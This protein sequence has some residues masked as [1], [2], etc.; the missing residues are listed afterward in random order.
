MSWGD[1]PA[2]VA[3]DE[4][5]PTIPGVGQDADESELD[6]RQVTDAYGVALAVLL[7]SVLGL[8]AA[9]GLVGNV[10]VYA[11]VVLQMVALAVTLRVSG[12][13]RA[14]LLAG[15]P[16]L[17]AV[18]FGAI[19]GVAMWGQTGDI[20]A[21]VAWLLLVLSTVVS[22]AKRLSGYRRINMRLILGL[23]CIYLLTG[24][25]FGLAYGIIAT[26]NP[27]AFSAP[28]DGLSGALYLSFVTLTTVG[29]GDVVAVSPVARAFVVAQAILGQLYL[30]SV[31]SLAVGRLGASRAQ[32][33]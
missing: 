31:V 27:A 3:T 25:S 17:L 12:V 4:T 22:I 1:S 5:R 20:V 9:G 8:I 26:V 19:V 21:Q 23:L 29:F 15:A 10:A 24:I 2:D 32:R 11:A 14:W 18:F 33:R 30:V 28:M 16:V 6:A 13:R 7:V